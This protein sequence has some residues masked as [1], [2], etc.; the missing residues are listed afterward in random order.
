M[1]TREP[2]TE[3]EA[4]ADIRRRWQAGEFDVPVPLTVWLLVAARNLFTVDLRRRQSE[5][6]GDM[7]QA[8]VNEP[9][10]IVEIRRVVRTMV[11][12]LPGFAAAV[13]YLKIRGFL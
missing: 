10:D 7:H 3:A 5:K 9:R 11:L 4:E 6:R 13:V 12:C 1:P 2:F 8:V